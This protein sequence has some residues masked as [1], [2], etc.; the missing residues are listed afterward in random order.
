MFCRNLLLLCCILLFQVKILTYDGLAMEFKLL[1]LLL[2]MGQTRCMENGTMMDI[3]NPH[4]RHLM[5]Q[6][7][8]SRSTEADILS[9]QIENLTTPDEHLTM[10]NASRPE[11]LE[12]DILF[13]INT[14]LTSVG[15]VANVMAWI[16]LLNTK[17]GFNKM[18]LILL[19]HQSVIDAIACV[20]SLSLLVKPDMW[21]TGINILDTFICYIWHSQF[22]YW[23]FFY[24]SMANMMLL[25]AERYVAV[26]HPFKHGNL[27][28]TWIKIALAFIYLFV[29]IFVTLQ[30]L[31]LSYVFYGCAF[32][33]V[34]PSTIVEDYSK[35][36]ALFS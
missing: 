31:D 14:A 35:G 11:Q 17:K 21:T 10:T 20:I 29:I 15:I 33:P 26:C 2:L 32:V 30:Y 8:A 3:L 19:Q 25:A 24:I 7:N 12:L 6:T 34:L 1:F 28:P 4:D 5:E 9:T 36:I 18:I 16:T 23:W 27:S 13:Y 22:L